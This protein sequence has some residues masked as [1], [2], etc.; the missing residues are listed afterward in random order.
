MLVWFGLSKGIAPL[1][2]IRRT[3]RNRKLHDLSPIDPTDAPEEIRPFIDSI[4]D[5]MRRLSVSMQVQQRFV[6]DAAHQMR[7]PLAGLKTQAE[8]ALRQ[9]D[10]EGIEQTMRQI[11]LGADRASRLINQLLA[12]ARAESHTPAGMQRLD[13]RAFSE[14][15]TRDWVALAQT[16]EIDLGYESDAGAAVVEGNPLLLRELL[17]NLIDNAIRYTPAG[18]TVTVRVGCQGETAV[19]DVEDNGSG[20]PAAEQALVFER[21]YR[22]L[23]TET[24]GSGLGLAIVREIAELHHGSARLLPTDTGALF[25]VTLPLARPFPLQLAA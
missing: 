12:L 18:G 24:E 5:L 21:F 16:R 25:R 20:I 17:G 15:V 22:V 4:N 7:T 19:I 3:I 2:E 23:G 11:A 10:L 13:L 8:L 9:R 14:S 6:A 1:E